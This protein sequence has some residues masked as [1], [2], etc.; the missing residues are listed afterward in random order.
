MIA[1]WTVAGRE[2]V[3]LI[4]ERDESGFCGGDQLR[5]DQGGQGIFFAAEAGQQGG[6]FLG[7]KAIPD[8]DHLLGGADQDAGL[9][10][11]EII[12]H[13]AG[14]RFRQCGKRML[15]L[16]TRSGIAGVS[17]FSVGL[18]AFR[19]FFRLGLLGTGLLRGCLLSFVQAWEGE[20]RD[21]VHVSRS[22]LSLLIDLVDPR[23]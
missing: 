7:G 21:L 19:C 22:S 23:F 10:F 6:L 4:A 5:R 8:V 3:K 9:G 11:S 17:V 1:A 15:A 16:S 2:K 13:G 14:S 12:A 20:I 18:A